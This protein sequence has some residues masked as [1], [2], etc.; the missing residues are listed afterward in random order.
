MFLYIITITNIINISFLNIYIFNL[1][2]TCK[3]AVRIKFLWIIF[4]SIN[5]RKCVLE[6]YGLIK[7]TH[8]VIVNTHYI[9]LYLLKY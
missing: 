9:F 1:E 7:K 8:Y 3:F 5:I 2:L 6:L 4:L